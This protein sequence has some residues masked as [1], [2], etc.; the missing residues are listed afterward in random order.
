MDPKGEFTATGE[1]QKSG[2]EP[3]K[4]FKNKFY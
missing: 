3:Y 4:K 2:R 1:S